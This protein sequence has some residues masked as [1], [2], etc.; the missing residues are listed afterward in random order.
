MCNYLTKLLVV[1]IKGAR[2]QKQKEDELLQAIRDN[3]I[4][5]I[6]ELIAN[7]LNVQEIRER[8]N[9]TLVDN[10]YDYL[11]KYAV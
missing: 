5:I 3:N 9:T 1:F 6:K 11:C 8:V 7:G 4:V 10:N 2:S